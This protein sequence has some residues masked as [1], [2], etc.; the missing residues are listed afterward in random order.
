[1]AKRA[2][3]RSLSDVDIRLI[4]VFITVTECGGFAASELELNIGRST[5]S[6]HIADLELRI[7]LKLCNRGPS[8]F[9]L[10]PEGEQVLDAA[11]ELLAAIDGFQAH[12]DNIHTHLTGTLRLGLFDQ[13]TTNPNAAV[14]RAIQSFDRTAPDVAFEIA[15]AP[16][17]VLEA[18]VTD[19]SLDVAIVPIHRQSSA[20]QYTPL[21]DEHMTLHCGEGHPLFHADPT[22]RA[23]DLDL[24][25]YKYAGYAFNSPNMMAGQRLGIR[26]AARVQE[27]EAL[28]LLIQSGRYL[29]YLADH[30]ADT[31][32]HKGAVRAVAPADTGY[33]T[34][35]AAILRKKPASDRK[36][37]EFL[38]CLI[39]AHA[40]AA[41][42]PV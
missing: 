24:A 7:G 19:G 38:R 8:G 28:S 31:L 6:K 37:E 17:G 12:I 34:R 32:L 15:L 30:V 14:H 20:L 18:R 41:S 1:M 9:S 36:A 23:A 13:S 40:T 2:L 25:R 26:R 4:R 21:Y 5:I 11:H 39:E 27:E 33:S 10:T 22:A 16:P 42:D 3:L 29:G 35:F